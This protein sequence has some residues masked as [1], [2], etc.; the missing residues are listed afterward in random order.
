MGDPP[1]T[2]ASA[3][4]SCG[5]LDSLDTA[6]GLDIREPGGTIDTYISEF[7]SAMYLM[8][9]PSHKILRHL[10]FTPVIDLARPPCSSL[11]RSAQGGNDISS[12][13]WVPPAIT[14][15]VPPRSG[16]LKRD[17]VREAHP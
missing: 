6:T 16:I 2:L 12:L 5:A 9:I 8:I 3:L 1:N 13:P 14:H 15:R 11:L 4:G 10:I 7:A 17:L